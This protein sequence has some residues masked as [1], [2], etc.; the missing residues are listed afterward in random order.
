MEERKKIYK[1]INNVTEFPELKNK[2]VKIV[3]SQYWELYECWSTGH[4]IFDKLLIVDLFA[5][6]CSIYNCKCMCW[7]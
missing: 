5:L 1:E 3:Y 2:P 6:A 4:W 7:F